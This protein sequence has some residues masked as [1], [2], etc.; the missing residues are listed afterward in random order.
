MAEDEDSPLSLLMDS[1]VVRISF[2]ISQS[3]S[4]TAA[5]GPCLIDKPNKNAFQVIV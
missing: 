5:M 1:S 4:V 2:V 3:L